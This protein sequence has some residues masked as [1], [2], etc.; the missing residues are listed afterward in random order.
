ML[1][2]WWK[3]QLRKKNKHKRDTAVAEKSVDDS[4]D[5]SKEVTQVTP[6]KRHDKK[7]KR[8]EEMSEPVSEDALFIQVKKKK[9]KDNSFNDTEVV[10]DTPQDSTSDSTVKKKY[11]LFVGEVNLFSFLYTS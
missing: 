2:R 4:V 9:K 3:E 5:E 6:A 10:E 7:R 1:P 11:I 8:K